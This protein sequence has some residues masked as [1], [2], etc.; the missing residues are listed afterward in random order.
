MGAALLLR[1][2]ERAALAGIL[3]AFLKVGVGRVALAKLIVVFE[4]NGKVAASR[5]IHL[6][7]FLW[8]RA[9]PFT[10]LS[11]SGI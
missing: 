8:L 6:I 9:H 2:G 3:R 5:P 11:A 1:R 4:V 7:C 10:L